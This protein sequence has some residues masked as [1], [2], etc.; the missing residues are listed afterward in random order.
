MLALR[1]ILVPT[2][3]SL[4]ST[5]ALEEAHEFA[6]QFSASIDLLY[7]WT[8]P[9]LVAPESLV[10][11]MGINEQPLIVWM[12]SSARVLLSRFEEQAKSAGIEVHASF[13]EPGDPA[14]TIVEHAAQGGYDLLV[15]GTHGRTGIAHALLGSVAEKV[16]RS[17]RC[18]VLTVRRPD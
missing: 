12:E 9:A 1:K 11:G 15:L 2:D 10:T 6:R 14:T 4:C 13:C 8:M 7:V 5:R 3:L 16:V 17:A 18:P